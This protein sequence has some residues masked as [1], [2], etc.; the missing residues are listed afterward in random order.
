M[1][2]KRQKTDYQIRLQSLRPNHDQEII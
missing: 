1:L 2:I